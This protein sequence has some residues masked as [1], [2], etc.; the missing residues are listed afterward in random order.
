MGK[1][2]Q[3]KLLNM[4]VFYDCFYYLPKQKW[5]TFVKADHKA[6]TLYS[7]VPQLVWGRSLPYMLRGQQDSL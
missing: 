2:I 6:I 4:E 3:H 5:L 7:L 1:P